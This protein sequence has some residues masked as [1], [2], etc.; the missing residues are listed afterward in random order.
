ML[1]NEDNL[2]G[3]SLHIMLVNEDNLPEYGAHVMLVIEDNLPE[4]TLC[5]NVWFI[6][7]FHHSG[8]LDADSAAADALPEVARLERLRDRLGEHGAAVDGRQPEGKLKE[9]GHFRVIR[10]SQYN[11]RMEWRL[12]DSASRYS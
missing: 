5:N 11:K 7:P 1:V 6:V 10:P 3:N 8:A 2:P 4:I 9:E 12:C